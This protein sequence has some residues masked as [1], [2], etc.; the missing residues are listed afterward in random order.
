[1]SITIEDAFWFDGRR[2]S[3]LARSQAGKLPH[4]S[5]MSHE[6]M[7]DELEELR[8]QPE[9]AQAVTWHS[10]MSVLVHSAIN[11]IENTLGVMQTRSDKTS[12]SL[13]S[14]GKMLK[15]LHRGNG[16]RQGRKRSVSFADAKSLPF[17]SSETT[18]TASDAASVK[19]SGEFLRLYLKLV[20][21]K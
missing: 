10:E 15:L 2:A 18:C 13:A 11:A 9:A 5:H 4:L 16:E 1:M 7:V 20:L 6:D 17:S 3:L 8:R 12:L 19:L 14:L 21:L